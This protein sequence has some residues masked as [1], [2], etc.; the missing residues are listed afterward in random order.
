MRRGTDGERPFAG[1]LLSIGTNE[2][3]DVSQQR[4]TE[5]GTFQFDLKP[6]VAGAR[7]IVVCKMP[8][9]LVVEV[10]QGPRLGQIIRSEM[11]A[12]I[13]L[14]ITEEEVDGLEIVLSI[15]RLTPNEPPAERSKSKHDLR[16]DGIVKSATGEPLRD[17]RI[18]IFDAK[19]G[20]EVARMTSDVDGSFQLETSVEV[21]GGSVFVKFTKQ[22]YSLRPSGQ[23]H[24]LARF[25]KSG[26]LEIPVTDLGQL[27]HL[28]VVMAVPERPDWPKRLVYACLGGVALVVLVVVLW[29]VIKPGPDTEKK[30]GSG[31]SGQS[32]NVDGRSI[33]V[34]PVRV[35]EVKL[36]ASNTNTTL[37]VTNTGLVTV[38]TVRI[39]DT[40]QY[41]HTNTSPELNPIP[42]VVPRIPEALR[43]AAVSIDGGPEVT[44][45]IVPRNTQLSMEAA[46]RLKESLTAIERICIAKG[47]IAT[48]ISKPVESRNVQLLQ[49]AQEALNYW[50]REFTQQVRQLGRMSPEDVASGGRYLYSTADP[51]L[52]I[53]RTD[54]TDTMLRQIGDQIRAV[55]ANGQVTDGFDDA[56]Y[57][58]YL[59][60]S[61]KLIE[62]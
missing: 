46:K 26:R 9:F 16:L 23:D 35:V 2:T 37:Y 5:D 59:K 22:G 52:L 61:N 41:R 40:G 32:S 50:K 12:R 39:N 44:F 8:G 11:P 58:E 30:T 45:E 42:F 6:A 38:V 20:S 57:A 14:P 25:V 33:V 34:Q 56:L 4:S 54:Y 1:V 31:A 36:T 18:E 19:S 53:K 51:E 3:E 24:S 17:V 21:T 10:R 55:T 48:Q 43:T 60:L 62:K 47:A 49:R 28:K 15:E 29:L 27:G 7:L 13:E